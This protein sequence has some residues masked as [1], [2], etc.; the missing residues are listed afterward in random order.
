ANQVIVTN[1]NGVAGN[2]TLSLP[3]DIGPTSS[4]TF[5]SITVSNGLDLESL[6]LQSNGHTITVQAPQGLGADY[7]LSLPDSDG[8]ANQLLSTDG[9]GELSWVTSSATHDLVT[10]GTANGLS[11]NDQ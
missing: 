4:P 3:Q 2:P 5:D 1:G 11:L 8:T 7:V 10:L 6:T 9:S